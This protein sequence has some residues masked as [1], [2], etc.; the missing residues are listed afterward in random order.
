MQQ[1]GL[2]YVFGFQGEGLKSAN[3]KY[4]IEQVFPT[5]TQN[6]G[7]L[8]GPAFSVS[9]AVAGVFMGILVDKVNR[10]DLLIVSTLIFS[11]SSMVSGYTNSFAVL[12]LMRF[13][14]GLFVSGIEPAGF[15]ILGDYF[16]RK[17][18]STANALLGTGGY[19]GGGI[20]ALLVMVIQKYGW[21]A[22]YY[23]QGIFGI[24]MAVLGLLLMREPERGAIDKTTEELC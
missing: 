17:K 22:A 8:S 24:V 21:R 1:Q 16:P 9:Y 23:V 13:I 2:S 12:F 18:R 7:L 20:S 11:I 10:K 6:Y 15:S 19:L 3:P 5:L 4:E 14:L